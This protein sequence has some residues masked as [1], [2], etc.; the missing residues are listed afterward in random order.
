MINAILV[1]NIPGNWSTRDFK[2]F[3]INVVNKDSLG[4]GL[5]LNTGDSELDKS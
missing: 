1:L 3:Q 4:D 5:I 2:S